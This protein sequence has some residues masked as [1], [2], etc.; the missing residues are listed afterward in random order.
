MALTPSEEAAVRDLIAQQTELLSL[1]ANEPTIISKL[2]APKVTLPQLSSASQV[3]NDDILLL[4]QG[5]LDKS[6]RIDIIKSFMTSGLGVP[7]GTVFA[8][9]GSAAPA[10]YL[11]CNG[12]A[13]S[14]VTYALLFGE[15]GT[16]HGAGD[17]ST[18][19]NVPDLRD[20]FI[21][22]KGNARAVGSKQAAAFGSHSHTI[23]DPGHGHT[24]SDP[25][26][27]HGAGQPAHNHAITTG[28]HS[29][30]VND[31]GHA[32][33]AFSQVLEN[34]DFRQGGPYDIWFHSGSTGLSGTGISIG[35]AGNLGGYTDARQPGVTV[36]AAATGVTAPNNVT[37]ITA[38]AAGDTETR[39][40]NTA[41]IYVIKY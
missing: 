15:L 41:L 7:V 5:V 21:R 22:G 24:L 9:G 3:L 18:T 10:G 31:P 23:T 27:V 20:E 25:G 4:R 37:G 38:A 6:V 30:G 32:H 8:V 17:G 39:P 12:Q 11:T 13:V 16:L 19:F 35:Q 1:A 29:H 2:A 28:N 36:S 40:Q 33:S 34:T 14:R 26:H